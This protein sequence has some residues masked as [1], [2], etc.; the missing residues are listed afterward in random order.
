MKRLLVL[1]I[2]ISFSST[3]AAQE[4][5]NIFAELDAKIEE[6]LS[7]DTWH[8]AAKSLIRVQWAEYKKACK[9]PGKRGDFYGA[10]C[11]GG[12]DCNSEIDDIKQFVGAYNYKG[13]INRAEQSGP[14][15]QIIV[16]SDS[17][18]FVIENGRRLPAFVNNNIVFFTDGTWVAQNVQLSSKRYAQLKMTMIYKAEH[19]G[20][21]RGPADSFVDDMSRL[22]KVEKKT[23]LKAAIR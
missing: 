17:R 11:Y 23:G 20:W 5:T 1:V 21:V 2:L 7:S 14:H 19:F 18:V 6:Q 12:I 3:V 16:S 4:T 15:F 22:V 8:S 10:K 13:L 9:Q